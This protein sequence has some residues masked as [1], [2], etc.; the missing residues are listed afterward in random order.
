[1]YISGLHEVTIFLHMKEGNGD[2]IQ[3]RFQIRIRHKFFIGCER[4]RGGMRGDRKNV[5]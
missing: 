2:P 1:M 5:P 3:G 4:A